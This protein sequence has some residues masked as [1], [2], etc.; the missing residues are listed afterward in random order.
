[1]VVNTLFAN[2]IHLPGPRGPNALDVFF[3]MDSSDEEVI[4]ARGLGL[5][6]L[7]RLYNSIR[8][9]IFQPQEFQDAFNRYLLEG[10][11]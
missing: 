7:Y 1:M 6:A 11:R 9:N 3:C 8:Y 10:L 2:G 5:Y 4:A